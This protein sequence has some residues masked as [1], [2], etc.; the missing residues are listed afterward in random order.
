MQLLSGIHQVAGVTSNVFLLVE[1]AGLTA[2]DS[3]GPGSGPKVLAYIRQIGRQPEDL[4]RILLTHQHVDHIGGAA[5]LVAQTGA[6]VLAHPL[7]APAIAGK[8]PRELPRNPLLRA[9]FTWLLLPRLQPVAITGALTPGETLPV[10]LEDGGLLV[11]ATPG[12]TSGHVS[13]YLPRRRV[14]FA[15]DAL[16]QLRGAVQ[17]PPAMFTTDMPTAR[18]SLAALAEMHVEASFPGHGRP[19]LQGAGERIA[20]TVKASVKRR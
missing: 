15:G 12:H 2:I 1:D 6:R 9:V 16:T 20:A 11:V 18:R 7:D 5:Y 17:A 10:M 4:R 19:M 3:G 13:L 8:A 14:L